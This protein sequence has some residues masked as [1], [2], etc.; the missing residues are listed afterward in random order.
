MTSVSALVALSAA[1]SST[2]PIRH[3]RS[4]GCILGLSDIF[5][6]LSTRLSRRAAQQ[7]GWIGQDS[8]YQQNRLIGTRQFAAPLREMTGENKNIANVI[9]H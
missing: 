6:T 1:T 5:L 9:T 3:S 2:N 7:Q 4:P 8:E